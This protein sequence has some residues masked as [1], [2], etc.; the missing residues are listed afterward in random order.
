MKRLLAV[1]AIVLAVPARCQV[2]ANTPGWFP[3]DMPGLEAESGT[4]VD[5]SALNAEPAGAHGFLRAVDGHFVDDR[6][7]RVRL[8]GA[9]ITGDSCFME[10]ETADRLALRLRQ[11]GFN[12]LRLHFMDFSRV[13]SVWADPENGTLSEEQLERL[14]Y[15][16]E[17]CAKNG[18]Y[19]NLN[20]HVAREYAG[21]PK[22]PGDRVFRMGKSLDRWYEPYVAQIETYARGLLDRKSTVTG[23][24]WADNP[25]IG[26]IEINNENTLINENRDAYRQLPDPWGSAFRAKW[27]AWLRTKYGTTTALRQAWNRDV[28]PLGDEMLGSDWKLETHSPAEARLVTDNGVTRWEATKAGTAFWHLQM[29]Y[30]DLHVPP[31][32]YTVTLRAR[33]RT[34]STVSHNL[35]LNRDPWTTVGLRATLKLTP[36]WQTFTITT[37]V[38]APPVDGPL[39]LNL[40]LANQ[41]GEVEIADYS[42]RPGGGK[43]LPEGQTLETGIDIPDD[44]VVGAVVDDW[45]AFLI[46]TEMATTKRLVA[47]LKKDL[48]CKSPISDTQVSYGGAGGVRRESETC[49]YIDIHGYWEHPSYTRSEKGWVTDFRINNTTQVSSPS[50][51][52][53]GGLAFHRVKGFPF[54]VSEYNTPAPN[55]HGA[56]LFPLLGA[57]AALQDWDALYSYT[58]RDFGKDYE[59]TRIR[60]YFH[61]IGRSDLLVHIPAAVHLFRLG[62]L[63]PAS[64]TTT[65]VLPR[66]QAAHLA[67]TDYRLTGLWNRLGAGLGTAWLRRVELVV[68]PT[69]EPEVQNGLPPVEGLVS[70]E[71]VSWNPT[72]EKGPW[73]SLDVPSVRLLIGHVGG[74]TV[75]VGDTTFAVDGRPWPKDLPAYACISLTALDGKPV[76]E[77][78]RLLLAASART[79][80]TN[81]KWN[82]DRTS[83]VGK[84]GWGGDTTVSE[85]VPL[86]LTLP[87]G[88]YRATALDS[89]GRPGKP[90]QVTGNA[91][92]LRAEDQTLWVLVERR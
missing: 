49:D 28:Q 59:D 57:M 61:L 4:P 71:T 54:S 13:G 69:G 66:D 63:Q 10:P 20:L 19:I 44:D 50:G 33:S 22:I 74:R 37:P 35:M 46:D 51:G 26:C 1:L 34:S 25:A 77:S 6:G 80:N 14:D 52:T 65:V 72:D 87:V 39:R 91:L 92:R 17:A 78:K 24:R 86:T 60:K 38:V 40:S 67:R 18:V 42:L 29:Q 53:L 47:F 64:E 81:M 73:F 75:P 41:A 83:L 11:W 8:I 48:G 15:L 7:Q 9:N 79:E 30:R 45:F 27:T 56:E 5:L 88:S 3:F 16:I 68:K 12:C 82:E 32:R 43:G 21:Q 62:A 70:S 58:Y 31:G 84:D 89:Q 55:D 85:A 23:V 90:V 76:A 2:D 36:E